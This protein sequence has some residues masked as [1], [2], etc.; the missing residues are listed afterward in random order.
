MLVVAGEAATRAFIKRT[1]ESVLLEVEAASRIET[2]LQ[3]LRSGEFGVI[4]LDPTAP[5][6]DGFDLLEEMSHQDP[7]LVRRTII[8]VGPESRIVEHLGSF[9]HCR[10]IDRPVMRS[11]LIEAVSECL[12]ESSARK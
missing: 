2:A 9:P 10:T 5:G 7:S 1:L 12:R 8:V 6:V 3:K 4:V 11:Q